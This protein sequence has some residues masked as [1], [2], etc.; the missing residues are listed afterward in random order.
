[1]DHNNRFFD[2][3]FLIIKIYT[4]GKSYDPPMHLNL[5]LKEYKIYWRRYI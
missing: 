3:T 4:K 5:K 2:K 1:M